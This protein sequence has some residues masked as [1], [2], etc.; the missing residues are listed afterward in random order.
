MSAYSKAAR[1]EREIDSVNIIRAQIGR[2]FY[3]ENSIKTN[4]DVNV[5]SPNF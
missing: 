2:L 4:L 5:I 1:V 3:I